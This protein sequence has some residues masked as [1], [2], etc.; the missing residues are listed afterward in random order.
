[1]L[2]VIDQHPGQIGILATNQ[3]ISIIKRLHL[4]QNESHYKDIY[5]TRYSDVLRM[6]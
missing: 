2:N 1:M 4:N 3:P 5:I 6:S